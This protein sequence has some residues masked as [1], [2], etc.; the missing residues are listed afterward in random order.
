VFCG[1]RAGRRSGLHGWLP[2]A[3]VAAQSSV[4]VGVDTSAESEAALEWALRL[5]GALGWRV[6]AVHAVGLLEGGGYRP[7]TDVV[8]LVEE[9]SRRIGVAAKAAVEEIAESGHRA[10]TIVRVAEREGASIIVVGSRGLGQAAR[11]LGSTSEGVLAHA[12]V[13]VLVMP[14]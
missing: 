10:E 2:S 1:L 3:L 14:G 9:A 5:A 13:P 11:L 6:F 8:G 12:R 7:R 4:V